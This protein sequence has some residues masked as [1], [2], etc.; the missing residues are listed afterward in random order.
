MRLNMSDAQKNPD[1]ISLVTSY[2]ENPIK[3]NSGENKP[4][5]TT[6]EKLVDTGS[7]SQTKTSLADLEAE[8]VET[9]GETLV[10]T[11][12]PPL[13]NQTA[14]TEPQPDTQTSTEGKRKRGRPPGVKNKPKAD[15]SDVLQATEQPSAPVDYK[16]LAESTFDLTTHVLAG[17]LGEE[18]R[19]RNEQE[20]QGVC[21]ALEAYMRTKQMR[22]IP[23][24]VMLTLVVVAYSTP[25]FTQPSTKMKLALAWQWFKETTV[26]ALTFFKR[27]K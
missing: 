19:P 2:P 13:D 8:T 23:P 24:G 18:W 17:T 1:L 11:E 26:K 12:T 9:T 14:K 15:F 3:E 16:S 4:V 21:V 20:R 25:R 27:K 10:T 7:P 22:D 6:G 5:E